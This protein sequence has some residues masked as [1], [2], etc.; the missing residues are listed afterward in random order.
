[1][2]KKLGG[3]YKYGMGNEC[4][5]FT[6]IPRSKPASEEARCWLTI[7]LKSWRK[8]GLRN[9]EGGNRQI[10]ILPNVPGGVEPTVLLHSPNKY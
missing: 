2:K 8:G 6:A 5:D 7:K 1:M 4:R 10:R 3:N 9:W